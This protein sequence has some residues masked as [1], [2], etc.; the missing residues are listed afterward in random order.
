MNLLIPKSYRVRHKILEFLSKERMKNGGLNPK[1]DWRFTIK[2][3]CSK[4][5]ENSDYV[6]SELDYLF[7]KKLVRFD[8]NDNEKTNPYC[9]ID[10]SGVE[11]YASKGLLNDGKLLQATLFNNISTGFFQIIVG[12]IAVATI[13]FN[14]MDSKLYHE[15]VNRLKQKV[16]N[17]T[18]VSKEL[19]KEKKLYINDSKS[20]NQKIDTL[21]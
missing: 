19:I 13:I 15:E 8:K 10:D 14:Y 17:Y 11:L 6:N 5:N 4:I 12:I 3:I 2:E 21:K 9:W 16:E 1:S 18:E 7:Y 20:L